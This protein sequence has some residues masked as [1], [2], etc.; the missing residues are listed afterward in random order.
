[1]LK[2]SLF[3]LEEMELKETLLT[4]LSTLILSIQKKVPAQLSPISLLL[5][6]PLL[7]LRQ[8]RLN[9]KDFNSSTFSTSPSH[10]CYEPW[11]WIHLCQ[12]SPKYKGICLLHNI[13]KK[14]NYKM[15]RKIRLNFPVGNSYFFNSEVCRFAQIWDL[16][17][18]S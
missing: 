10:T 16:Q 1:M 13:S 4:L 14:K 17:L 11:D 5:Q 9:C 3:V 18:F 8:Q 2:M 12:T 6:N 15:L 7:F